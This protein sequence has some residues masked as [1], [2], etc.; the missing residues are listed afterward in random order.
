MTK[1]IAARLTA[2]LSSDTAIAKRD[3]PLSTASAA[4]LAASSLFLTDS[5]PWPF[6]RCYLPTYLPA[7]E[8][9]GGEAVARAANL[10]HG[11]HALAVH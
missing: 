2:Q 10:H 7:R 4:A 9:H 1:P 6:I 11:A 5:Y 8:V 3:V